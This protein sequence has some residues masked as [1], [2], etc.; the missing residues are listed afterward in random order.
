[1]CDNWRNSC[2]NGR[3]A[4]NLKERRKK[5]QM[6]PVYVRWKERYQQEKEDNLY[7]NLSNL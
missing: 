2:L 3:Q 6:E 1:M 4:D 5:N 7:F